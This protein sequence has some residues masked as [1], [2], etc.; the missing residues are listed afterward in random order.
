MPKYKETRVGGGKRVATHKKVWEDANGPIPDG[1]VVHHKN[2]DKHDNRLEN[3][4]LLSHQAHSAHHNQKHPLTS[5]CANCGT[6]FT[7]PP[8]KRGRKKNCSRECYKAYAS[9][10]YR[11]NAKLSREQ[12]AEIRRRLAQGERGKDLALEYEVSPQ[13]IS[14]IRHAYD[15]GA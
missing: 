1:F 5:I 6:E 12:H 13:S 15:E 3:L 11:N 10:H 8:T 14:R 9:Q 4:E 7:P 2:G